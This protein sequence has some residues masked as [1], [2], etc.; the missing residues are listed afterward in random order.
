MPSNRANPSC[1]TG[2][3]LGSLINQPTATRV[4][5]CVAIRSAIMERAFCF[6]NGPFCDQ[7]LVTPQFGSDVNHSELVETREHTV[8]CGTEA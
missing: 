8:N 1:Q 4:A 7:P 5:A 2:T 3:K 6:A